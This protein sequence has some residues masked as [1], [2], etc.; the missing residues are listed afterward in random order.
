M[1]GS[2]EIGYGVAE[3]IPT[4]AVIGA[5]PAQVVPGKKAAGP[6]PHTVTTGIA[7]TGDKYAQRE[8]YIN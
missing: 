7:V 2:T 1:S 6:I 5:M 8:S 3:D 4:I